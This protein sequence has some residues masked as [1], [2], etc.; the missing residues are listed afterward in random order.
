MNYFLKHNCNKQRNS[1]FTL[2]IVVL[3]SNV[4]VY[5]QSDENSFSIG[6]KENSGT[7]NQESPSTI[8]TNNINF[9]LWFMGSKQD[10]NTTISTEE[11]DA[12][13][14][15]LTSGMAPNRVLIKAFLQKAVN[16]ECTM[17]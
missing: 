15:I 11:T 6:G 9:L 2:L 17:T 10:P 1:I 5:G 3:L 7:T 8:S 4:S 16:A 12:K 14:Q 13:I